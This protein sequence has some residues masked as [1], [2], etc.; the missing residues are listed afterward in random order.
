MSPIISIDSKKALEQ[1][2][3][4]KTLR[5]LS[6]TRIYLNV[7]RGNMCQIHTEHHIKWEKA[8]IIFTKNQRS[9]KCP[10]LP[11]LIKTALEVRH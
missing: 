4:I 9:T 5:K 3:I 2:F 11:L 7:N 1:T 6:L 8:R 10:V